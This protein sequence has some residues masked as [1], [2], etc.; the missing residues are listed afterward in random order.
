MTRLNIEGVED[1]TLSLPR[2]LCLHGGGTNSRIFRAQCRVIVAHLKSRFRFCFAEAPIPSHAGPDVLSVYKNLGPFRAWLPVLPGCPA[3]DSQTVIGLIQ[4]SIRTAMDEDNRRGGRGDWIGLLGFS[5][6]AKIC[7]SLL[8]HQHQQQL[9]ADK[10]GIRYVGPNFR[11]AVLLAGRAPLVALEPELAAIPALVDISQIGDLKISNG[12]MLRGREHKLRLP[13]I[14][15]HGMKDPG[16]HLHRQ[17]LDQYCEEG[18]ATLIE[19]DGAHRVPIKSADVAAVTKQIL[20]VAEKTGVFDN[21]VFSG[22]LW[23]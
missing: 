10:L 11:F 8:F 5:Q 13:T 2:I 19:W 18:S 21:S 17:L 20:N 23:T 16:L 3:I 7:A 9:R 12:E 6:G 15:V 1:P 22:L 14:H 4:D